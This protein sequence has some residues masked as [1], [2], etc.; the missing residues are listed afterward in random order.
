MGGK[1]TKPIDETFIA[2]MR[3]VKIRG[4]TLC[5]ITIPIKLVRKHDLKHGQHIL[6]KLVEALETS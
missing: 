1:V 5:E 3:C 2:R 6:V 4:K